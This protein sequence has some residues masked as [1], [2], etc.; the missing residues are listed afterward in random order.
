MCVT[1]FVSIP[2]YNYWETYLLATLFSLLIAQCEQALRIS[3]HKARVLKWENVWENDTIQTVHSICFLTKKNSFQDE[4]STKQG[5]LQH[6]ANVLLHSQ[7]YVL[8]LILS[9]ALKNF[10]AFLLWFY[11]ILLMTWKSVVILHRSR[12]QHFM[13]DFHQQKWHTKLNAFFFFLNKFLED[14]SPFCGATDTP[15][16][17]FWWRLPWVSKPGWIPRLRASSPAHN[18]E[19]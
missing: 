3:F 14:M 18:E 7:V 12:R 9:S 19:A 16:L 6:D 10:S 15:V 1:F 4:K 2:N 5:S 8:V 11:S 17:D 13:G